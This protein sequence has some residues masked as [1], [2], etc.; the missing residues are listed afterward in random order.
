MD[1]K[2]VVAN[3]DKGCMLFAFNKTKNVF[4]YL[5]PVR[6]IPATGG[7]PSQIEVTEMDSEIKQYILDRQETPAYEFDYNYTLNNYKKCKE[8]FDGRT[9]NVFLITYSDKSGVKFKGTGAT[10]RDALSTGAEIK[11]KISVAVSS[12]DDVDDCS[13]IIDV[14]TI[15]TGKVH[16]FALNSVVVKFDLNGGTGTTIGDMTCVVGQYIEIPKSNAVVDNEDINCWNTSADG[17]GTDIAFGQKF[18]PTEDTTLYAKYT[19]PSEDAGE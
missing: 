17:T 5:V 15:P 16:P 11:A 3:S 12:V 18:M 10:W 6:S 8:Y 4:E 19:N 7:S 1:E 2:N 14:A 13:S 9:E